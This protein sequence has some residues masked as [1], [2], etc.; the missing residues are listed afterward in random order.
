MRSNSRSL[1]SA[2]PV[3]S[4]VPPL[5]SMPCV[6]ARTSSIPPRPAPRK[7]ARRK[8]SPPHPPPSGPGRPGDG[9][10]EGRIDR[11]EADAVHLL[12]AAGDG[13]VPDLDLAGQLLQHL[14]RRGQA[15]D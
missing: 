10:E 9:Q 6:P 2:M 15:V 8:P 7:V 1:T 13:D 12:D 5:R 14:E 4:P 3:P 11:L